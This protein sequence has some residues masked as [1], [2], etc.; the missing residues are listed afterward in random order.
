M[1]SSNLYLS[2][3][4]SLRDYP[5][6]HNRPKRFVAHFIRKISLAEDISNDK[7][8]QEDELFLLKSSISGETYRVSFGSDEVLPSC[9]CYDWKKNLMLCKDIMAVMRCCKDITWESLA[10][11]YKNSNFFETDVDVIKGDSPNGSKTT[12]ALE[13]NEIDDIH[14]VGNTSD[15][16]DE[17]SM[18]YF[19]KKT[20]RTSYRELL[21][22]LKSL[23]HNTNDLEECFDD[24]EIHLVE[25]VE[26]LKKNTLADHGL[27]VE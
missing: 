14:V 15:G 23:S 5:W 26:L 13:K 24:L 4:P 21:N 3:N 16:F 1:K 12:T 9:S 20:K 2:Y 27:V 11:A 22:E 25:M 19:P 10:P 7:I 8:K 18:K 17:I 6:L